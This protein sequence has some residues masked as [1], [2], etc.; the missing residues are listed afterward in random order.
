[1]TPDVE[2]IAGSGL[3]ATLVVIIRNLEEARVRD[4]DRADA[5]ARE[6]NRAVGGI[7]ALQTMLDAEKPHAVPQRR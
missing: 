1:M 6:I 4:S 7:H 5:C 2:T 3:T